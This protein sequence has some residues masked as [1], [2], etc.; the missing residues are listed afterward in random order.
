MADILDFSDKIYM[1]ERTF[2]MR[3]REAID[4]NPDL[5]EA[6][7]ARD[8]GLD[9]S[10]IRQLLSGKAKN[11]RMDTAMK[12]CK[13]LGT[14]IEDFMGAGRDSVR[15]EILDLYTQLTEDERRFLLSAAKGIASD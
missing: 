5:T 4:A 11:P 10:T 13:A 1:D 8:A 9:N 12:I 3:L 7:L 15:S 6:G 2:A 14:T